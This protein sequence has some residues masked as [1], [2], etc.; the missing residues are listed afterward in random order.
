MIVFLLCFIW[1]PILCHI[2]WESLFPLTRK[3]HWEESLGCSGQPVVASRFMFLGTL[4]NA[5]LPGLSL[6][7]PV[8]KSGQSCSNGM[9]TCGPGTWE[10]AVHFKGVQT[11]Q[12]LITTVFPGSEIKTTTSY[13][14]GYNWHQTPFVLTQDLFSVLLSHPFILLPSRVPG[15][16]PSAFTKWSSV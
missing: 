11:T 7:H 5:S 2:G 9:H 15:G 3:L 6:N 4:Y 14:A 10:D 16:Q 12:N 1:Q 13:T 8:Y